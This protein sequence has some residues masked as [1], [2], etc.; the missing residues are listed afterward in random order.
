M[1]ERVC[2]ARGAFSGGSVLK[3]WIKFPALIGLLSTTFLTAKADFTG[4]APLAWRWAYSTPVAPSGTPVIDGNTAYVAVGSRVFALDRTTGNQKWRFPIAEGI[5]GYFRSAP[6]LVEG[7]LVA[8]ADNRTVYGVDPANGSSK[9]QYVSEVPII[10]QPVAVGKFVAFTLSDNSLMVIRAGDG[11]AAWENPQ[12]IF[13]GIQGGLAAYGDSIFVITG[14]NEVMSISAIT[15]KVL[16]K[17]RFTNITS[18]STPVVFGDNVY[19]NAGSY[20]SVFSAVSGSSRWQYNVGENL[21]FSPAVSAEGVASIS[22]DGKVYAFNLQGN[23]KT[24]TK[25]DEAGKSTTSNFV[26]CGSVPVTRPSAVGKL[27]LFPTSNGAIN[28]VDIGTSDILWSYLIRPIT[29]GLKTGGSGGGGGGG[30]GGVLGGGGERGGAGGMGAM[31]GGGQGSAAQATLILAIPAAGPGVVVG[32]TLYVLAR[33]GSLLAFDKEFGVDLTGPSV[34]MSW[35]TPG[36][37]VSG[38]PP[39]EFIFKIE[40]DASGINVSTLKIDVNG[41]ALDYTFG[42]DGLAWIRFSTL[43]KNKPLFDGRK[44]ITVTVSDWMGNTTKATFALTIDN[45]LRPL[46][47]P[48][49]QNAGNTGGNRG[50]GSRGGNGDG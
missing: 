39:L 14:I 5:P 50:G 7:T 24:W 10:G 1:L 8:A 36:D 13:D 20:V 23:R 3:Q 46:V 28:L 30:A 43:S 25:K 38:Q 12:R 4:P 33:D 37:V 21:A 17:N 47:R 11:T 41:T 16:W 29:P 19:L 35:P 6:L 27:F 44:T 40:D 48:G 9:W 15:K 18:D 2:S 49:A 42:R 34:S 32:N 45:T 26:D 31:G 22:R